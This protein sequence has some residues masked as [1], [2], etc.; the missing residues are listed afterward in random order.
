MNEAH[1]KTTSIEAQFASRID[2]I[3]ARFALKLADRIQQ[4]DAALSQMADG[5]S[6]AVDA[7]ATAYRWF[8]DVSGIG[9]TL[10]FETTGREA[11]NCADILVNP[12]RTRRGL[13]PD[14]LAS[15]TH[16]LESVRIAALRETHPI[17]SIHRTAP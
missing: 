2:M 14:E 10:G 12:F 13:S 15:L 6:H 4:T 16:G 7:V 5:R 3:R 1:A 9:P 11:R 8:H 17:E